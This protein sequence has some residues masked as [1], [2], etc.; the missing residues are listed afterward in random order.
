MLNFK[1]EQTLSLPKISHLIQNLCPLLLVLK[2]WNS[3]VE[4]QS[5]R[6]M[7]IDS[8]AWMEKKK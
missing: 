2:R 8:P 5:V 7:L 1:S 4:T 6:E 3:K